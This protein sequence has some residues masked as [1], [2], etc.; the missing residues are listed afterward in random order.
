MQSLHETIANVIRIQIAVIT[1][2]LTDSIIHAKECGW[3][4]PLLGGIVF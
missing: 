4:N 1:D 3:I 2:I